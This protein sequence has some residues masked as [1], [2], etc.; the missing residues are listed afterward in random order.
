MLMPENP[1]VPPQS[2]PPAMP[3]NESQARTWNMFCHLSALAG[4]VIP[5]GTVIGPLLVW[6]IK[7][8]E[9]PSVDEHGKAA[10][11]FQLTVLIALVVSGAAAVLLSFVCIGFILIP[12]VIGIAL[13]GLIFAIIAGIKA[14]NGEAY[15]YPWS[16]TLIK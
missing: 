14:N 15:R 5:F 3:G 13:C 7:K 6:Q 10:L 16:L 11:N 1:G 9:F 12:V 2:P 4:Y 8:N